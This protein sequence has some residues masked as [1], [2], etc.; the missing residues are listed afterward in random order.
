MRRKCLAY[1]V[2]M[3]SLLLLIWGCEDNVSYPDTPH[4][5]FHSFTVAPSPEPTALAIGTLIITFED[6]N[7]DIGFADTT[8]TDTSNLFI[9]THY[10]QNERY[11][12]KADPLGYRVP[13]IPRSSYKPYAKGEIELTVPFITLPEDSIKFSIYLYDRAGNRSNIL[14]TPAVQIQPLQ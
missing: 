8:L 5:S 7:A 6:G 2:F 13:E 11:L 12:A 4:I 1:L 3:A 10:L 9:T 14:T